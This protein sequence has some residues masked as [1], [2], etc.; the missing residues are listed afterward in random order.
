MTAKYIQLADKLISDIESGHLKTGQRM[1]SIRKF[2]ILYEVS[3]TTALN[4]FQRMQDQ[5]WLNAKPQS[6]FFITQ[7]F[8]IKEAP[9]F[10]QF[11]SKVTEPLKNKF[12]SLPVNSPFHVSLISPA[13]FPEQALNKC[14]RHSMSQ[15]Q[16]LSSLY[17]EYQGLSALRRSL[18]Q[19]FSMQYFPLDEK[20][21]IITN[22]CI[23]ALRTA[24]EV[25]TNPG[26][27]IAVAS[28]CFSGL[29]ELLANMNRRVVELPF[30]Q[31]QLDLDQL[32][33]HMKHKTITACLLSA[34][35]I[36]P[37][38]LC[39]SSVQKMKLAEMA[40][41]YKTPIIEDDVYLELSYSKTCP[42][43][44]KHWDKSGWVL[45]CSSIS[46]TISPSLRLGWCEPGRYF[47]S[48]LKNRS[49]QYFGVNLPI[50]KAIHEFIFS[51]QYLKHLNNIRIKLQKNLRDY[52]EL[53]ANNLPSSARLSTPTG[54]LVI[55]IQVPN[56]NADKLLSE[57][58]KQNIYFRTGNQFSTLGLYQDCFRLNIG[59]SISSADSS[60]KNLLSQQLIQ[61]CQLVKLQL[62]QNT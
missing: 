22:G 61:L 59:W 25:T 48:F 12:S 43:P 10:P 37:Q 9:K 23:D 56:L 3:I 32:E 60:E 39:L 4:C 2:S 38:G 27:A 47:D 24:I 42:L 62:D 44:I 57:T 40:K 11:I 1:P 21:L 54:G 52:H 18:S 29:L 53:L 8:G 49:I 14:F 46:K 45:W 51:G 58:I 5:G 26:D 17:P 50:Q 35:H 6:G 16:N 20:K 13:L 15:K 55:W 41:Q 31:S 34:N 36:N 30:S 33:S 28:P 19:H 7:P